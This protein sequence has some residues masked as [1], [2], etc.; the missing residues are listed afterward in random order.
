MI[1]VLVCSFA[2]VTQL[3]PAGVHGWLQVAATGTAVSETDIF[4]S[5]MCHCNIITLI[6]ED[7]GRWKHRT[8]SRRDR[9]GWREGL[10]RHESR[11][12]IKRQKMCSS[13]PF[14]TV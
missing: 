11:Q 3:R 13:S 5:S 12:N 1:L 14:V 10:G 7:A 6:N 9:L 8:F 2:N 4:A